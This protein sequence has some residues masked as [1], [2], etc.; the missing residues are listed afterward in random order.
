MKDKK[1]H[2]RLLLDR[3]MDGLESQQDVSEL[4]EYFNNTTELPE[5]WK[6]YRD[7]FEMMERS[8]NIPSV[9]SLQHLVKNCD[10]KRH[11][12][13]WAWMVAACVAGLVVV[14]LK[15]PRSENSDKPHVAQVERQAEP[16]PSTGVTKNAGLTEDK[17]SKESIESTSSKDVHVSNSDDKPQKQ[18]KMLEDIMVPLREIN[19]PEDKPFIINATDDQKQA[20]E[21]QDPSKADAYIARLAKWN[22]IEP[23]KM[24]CSITED[25][26]EV[27]YVYVFPDKESIDLMGKLIQMACWYSSDTPGF[28]LNFTKRQFFLQLKD[29][30]RHQTYL[31]QAER[32]KGAILLYGVHAPTGK[33]INAMCYRK[34][35]EELMANHQ[36]PI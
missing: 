32:I 33:S 5:E 7:M 1:E 36:Q 16:V 23:V 11:T 31:W 25:S 14:C 20:K 6:V 28:F 22:G 24:D 2:I 3:Y 29:E 8:P 12:R 4:R 9:K 18:D 27:S 21:Y 30:Q 35:R 34:Y 13:L 26:T 19:L 17:R 15:P 10:I